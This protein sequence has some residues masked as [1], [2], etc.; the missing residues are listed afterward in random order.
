MMLST[1]LFSDELELGISFTPGSLLEVSDS[2]AEEYDLQL[3][4]QALLGFH[5]GYSFWWLFYTS[6]DSIVAPPPYIEEQTDVPDA[7]GFI[8]FFDV[9][10]R[11]SL[12]PVYILATVGINTTYV[13]SVAAHEY[14]YENNS[15]VGANVRLGVGLK[16]SA[17]SINLVGTSFYET[18]DDMTETLGGLFSGEEERAQEDFLKTLIPSIGFVLHL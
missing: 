13:H 8:N 2:V 4:E 9:G 12:G 10:I 1:A 15:D 11:P 6:W 16:F 17:F 14:G 18:F 5:V 3:E 7:A